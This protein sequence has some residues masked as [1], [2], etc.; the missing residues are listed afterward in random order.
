MNTGL[1]YGDSGDELRFDIYVPAASWA[2]RDGTG[3]FP[4][5]LNMN[6]P[7]SGDSLRWDVP[8]G[9]YSPDTWQEFVVDPTSP[10]TTTGTPNW[11]EIYQYMWQFY[12][13]TGGPGTIYFDNFEA[14]DDDMLDVDS[15]ELMMY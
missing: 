15:W 9:A 13:W 7:G 4:L 5:F 10:T 2:N 12:N 11:S 3:I 1:Q 14:Y 8:W 6:T